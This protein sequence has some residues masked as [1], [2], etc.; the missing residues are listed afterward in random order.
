MEMNGS[1]PRKAYSC[2]W[3][4]ALGEAAGNRCSEVN[5]MKL[6][7]TSRTGVTDVGEAIEISDA[8]WEVL[9]APRGRGIESTSEAKLHEAKEKVIRMAE[10]VVVAMK[11]VTNVERR[12][13][14]D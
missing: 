1:K 6:R 9:K 10:S 13:D 14:G 12:I 4:D 5:L 7:R 3:A 2:E 8:T 11:R